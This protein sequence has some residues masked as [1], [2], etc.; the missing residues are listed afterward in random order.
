ME[1]FN[2]F[3]QI[4][5]IMC[6]G[7]YLITNLQWYNY[8]IERVLLKHH[9]QQWHIIYFATPVLLFYILPSLYFV[10]QGP[11]TPKLSF[12][13]NLVIKISSQPEDKNLISSPD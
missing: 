1:Y 5:L 6:L 11:T 3:T 7:Y 8:K 12:F 13:L 2:L 4:L 10:S 9:K